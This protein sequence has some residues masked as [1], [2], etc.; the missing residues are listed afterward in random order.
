A[1]ARADGEQGLSIGI[2]DAQAMSMVAP[3]EVGMASGFLNTVRGGTGA[4]MLTVFGALLLATLEPRVGSPD[5]AAAVSAGAGGHAQEFTEAW[6]VT[7]WTITALMTAL[8]LMVNRLLSTPV[9]KRSARRVGSP[10]L[11]RSRELGEGRAQPP[12]Q[13]N[14]TTTQTE[15]T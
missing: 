1:L 12:S 2:I 6:Q 14:K 13:R 10:L 4:I 5:L 15:T 11:E 9:G 7:L 8:A 3:S